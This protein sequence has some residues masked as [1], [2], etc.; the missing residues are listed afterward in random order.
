MRLVR[1]CDNLFWILMGV[2][3][4]VQCHYNFYN[5]IHF[6]QDTHKDAP[7]LIRE[8]QIWDVFYWFESLT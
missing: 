1:S 4:G 7:W 3:L 2:F 5:M 8:G 6:L